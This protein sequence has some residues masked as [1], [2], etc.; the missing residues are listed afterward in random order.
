MVKPTALR[1]ATYY[2]AFYLMFGAFL[3]Y[4][5]R[6]LDG[7]GLSPEWI[8]WILAAGMIGRTLVSPI[9]ARWADRAV[10]HRDPILAFAIGSVVVFALHI[11]VDSPWLLVVLSFAAG[12]LVFGQIPVTDAFAI[13][14]ARDHAFEFGPVRAFGSALFIVANFTAGALIDRTGTESVLAWV[15]I[16]GGLMALAAAWLPPGHRPTAHVPRPD[17]WKE[18]RRRLAGPLGLALAASALIQ[19]GHAFYYVVSA[20]AWTQ[21][22]IS[23]AMVGTLWASAVAFEIAFLWLSGRGWL[24][25][26]SPAHLMMLG[27]LASLV[28]WGLT[29]LSP[30]VW[31]LFPL[32]ALHAL[33]FAATYVG[34]LRFTARDMPDDQTALSQGLNSALSGG[35]I[36][37]AMSTLSGYA[38]ASFGVGGFAFM[39]VP[40][41]LGLVAAFGLHR[42]SSLPRRENID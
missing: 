8:G 30:P 19:S 18:L 15:I 31:A 38:F 9:G 39:M 2:G 12:A 36:L 28:R 27:G 5:P 29:A 16:A 40:G 3:P 42:V 14:A 17:E 41:L 6:W 7:R 11:P 20:N 22:G 21:Q 24:G 23:G 26:L 34:F 10:R 35:I 13:R 37:A 32:Q 1:F 4:F 25:R 33:T